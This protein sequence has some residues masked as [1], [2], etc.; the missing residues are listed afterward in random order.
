MYHLVYV[1]TGAKEFSDEDLDSL[2]SQSREKNARLDI[3]G[4]L[5]YSRGTF[6][7]ILEGPKQAV[8]DVLEKIKAD[9][10]H[11]GMIVLIQKEQV[12]REFDGW[13]MG[14]KRLDTDA[15][16]PEAFSDDWELPFS[17]EEFLVD[18]SR[19][20]RLLLSFRMATP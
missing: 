16:P 5:L 10:R 20:L 19:A 2:L 12:S 6:M 11:R 7:Q 15:E 18:P 8:L 4:L 9:P 3:T 14:F 13:S 1:S 17:S